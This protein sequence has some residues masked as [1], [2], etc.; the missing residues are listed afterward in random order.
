MPWHRANRTSIR[1]RQTKEEEMKM[2]RIAFLETYTQSKATS[3]PTCLFPALSC[4]YTGR[5]RNS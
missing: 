4:R 3:D 2:P 1:P 5:D